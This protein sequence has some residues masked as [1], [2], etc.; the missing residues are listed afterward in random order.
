MIRAPPRFPLPFAAQRNFRA[1]PA[2]GITSPSSGWSIRWAATAS[3]P[4]APISFVAS[5]LN[6]GN[7]RTVIS[8]AP[9]TLQDYTALRY[10]RRQQVLSK[11]MIHSE[12][13]C[14]TGSNEALDH[15]IA[16]PR[17]IRRHRA[18]ETRETGGCPDSGNQGSARRC[19]YLG[20]WQGP[21]DRREVTTRIGDHLRFPLA[22]ERSCD[23]PKGHHR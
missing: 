10:K 20:R 3:I 6:F 14:Y 19:Q 8:P 2:P 21:G 5:A 17:P 15:R 11:K 18:A 23:Q 12:Y 22:G 16:V 7:C 13:A 9:S 4:S 1:P